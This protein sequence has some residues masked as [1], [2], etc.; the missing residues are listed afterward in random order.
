M[1]KKIT[2]Q[3]LNERINEVAEYIIDYINDRGYV[4]TKEL[5]SAM[6]GQNS[7]LT[8]KKRELTRFIFYKFVG[9]SGL[10]SGLSKK[11]YMVRPRCR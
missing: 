6:S 1:A 5:S 7:M 8:T 3:E 2:E 9:A 11:I 4:W 10:L